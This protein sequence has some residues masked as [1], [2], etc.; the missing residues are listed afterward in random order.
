MSQTALNLI[1]LSIFVLTF[2][3]LLG[4]LLHLSPVIPAIATF[5]L[6]GLATIDS[7]GLQGK[8]GSLLLD[9]LASISPQHR[10]RVV[11]HEA[12][13]FLIAH[14]LG[15]PV[16]GYAISAWEAIQSVQYLSMSWELK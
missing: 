1:A 11:R 13:H 7:F 5:S 6:L 14:I 16:T 2:S 9:L 10:A 8:G 12:G 3:S 4:P 15:I